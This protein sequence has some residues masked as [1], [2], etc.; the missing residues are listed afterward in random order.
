MSPFAWQSNKAIL[1]YFIQKPVSEIQFGTGV[2]R[3]RFWHQSLVKSQKPA[4]Y[5]NIDCN[6]HEIKFCRE[7]QSVVYQA[8]CYV[9][10]IQQ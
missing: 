8:L 5:Q 9:L 7:Y 4:F 3:P 2:Q 1:L 10:G 6:T